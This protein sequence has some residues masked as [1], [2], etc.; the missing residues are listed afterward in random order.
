[1]HFYL[2]YMKILFTIVTIIFVGF[3]TSDLFGQTASGRVSCDGKGVKDVVV[4]D[5]IH[6]TQTNHKGEYTITLADNASFVYLSTPA[7]YLPQRE[8]SVPLFYQTI[9]TGKTKGYD[10]KLKR[11]P[12]DDS[13]H[14]FMVH[15]DA[16]LFKQDNLKPYNQILDDCIAFIQDKKDNEIFGIDCG[17]LVGDKP[18]LYPDYISSL[19]RLDIPFYRVIGNHDMKLY[20]RSHET[21]YQKFEE[22]FG[23]SYYSFNK[24]NAHYIVLNDVFYLARDYF[25]AGYIEEKLLSW[26]EKDLSYIKK[27]S[28]VFIA[29]H[30]P[31]RLEIGQIPF[32]YLNANIAG[33][34]SNAAFLYEI[35]KPYRAHLLTGHTHYNR[36]LEHSEQL[37]EHITAAVCGTWWQGSVCLDGTPQGYGVYEVDNDSVTWYFKSA[38]FPREYQMRVYTPGS[39]PEYPNDVIANVWNWDAKWKVEWLENGILMGEMTRISIC[40]PAAEALCA[41]KEKLEFKWIAANP[42]DHMFRATIKNK[43]AK[44]EVLVTDRFGNT[45]RAG[46]N[47]N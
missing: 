41:D 29:M 46:L 9:Q 13:K 5:G 19:N 20:G 26:L 40:D 17:D 21:S 18:E 43:N 39:S 45:F 36:N 8:Q 11:N 10:F 24:G 31:T 37:Y 25:Y 1:M 34:V 32:E 2:R 23:P 16:Q 12:H 15:A 27:G 6:F 44:I 35:L 4:T 7:G 14:I 3:F 22:I 33:R 30:I 38:G 47:N 28:L 42:N